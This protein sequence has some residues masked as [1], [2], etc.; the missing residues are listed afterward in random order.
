[1]SPLRLGLRLLETC[2]SFTLSAARSQESNWN[3]SEASANSSVILVGLLGC[4]LALLE[5]LLPDLTGLVEEL[6]RQ[7]VKDVPEA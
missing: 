4:V 5:L 2:R 7:C 1:L 6:V 3:L